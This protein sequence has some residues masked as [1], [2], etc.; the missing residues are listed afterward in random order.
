M[1]PAVVNEL[2]WCQAGITSTRE[3]R[4]SLIEGTTESATDGQETRCQ[5]GDQVLARTGGDNGVHGTVID[6]SGLFTYRRMINHLPRHSG[7]VVSCQHQDH[8]NELGG[9]WGQTPLEPQQADNTAKADVLLEDVGDT[10]TSIQ[11]LLATLV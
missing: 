6:V 3:H 5:R 1:F 2:S 7:T 4:S 11:Q 8:L 10:H 9:P